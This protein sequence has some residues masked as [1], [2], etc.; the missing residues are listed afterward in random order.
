MKSGTIQPQKKSSITTKFASPSLILIISDTNKANN[1]LFLRHTDHMS[2]FLFSYCAMELQH[3]T[4]G[5]ERN[6]TL[7]C[8]ATTKCEKRG[9]CTVIKVQ[10]IMISGGTNKVITLC[11]AITCKC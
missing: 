10:N 8:L 2:I 5:M 11:N 3:I 6:A 1:K 4:Q 7:N 9:S